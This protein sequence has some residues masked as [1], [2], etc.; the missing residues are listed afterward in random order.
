MVANKLA[1]DPPQEIF[2]GIPKMLYLDSS[3]THGFY[4]KEQQAPPNKQFVVN[5][6]SQIA[7][8]VAV[9]VN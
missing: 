9:S 8:T 3:R 6:S 7:I 2:I 5:V 4:I 1:A